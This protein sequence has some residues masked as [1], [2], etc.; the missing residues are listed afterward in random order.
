MPWR[1]FRRANIGPWSVRCC[2][3]RRSHHDAAFD[4]SLRGPLTVEPT[5]WEG[6]TPAGLRQYQLQIADFLVY[7]SFH[8][9]N[10]WYSFEFDDLAIEFRN[11]LPGTVP[12]IQPPTKSKFEKLL[13]ALEKVLPHVKGDLVLSRAALDNWRVSLTVRHA[14][15]LEP[16]WA[17]VLCYD[18]VVHGDVWTA[19]GL[20]FQAGRG[21]RPGEALALAADDLV[22][23]EDN[24]STVGAGL[25]LLGT[26]RRTKSG[27]RQTVQTRDPL[28]IEVMRAVR[29]RLHGSSRIMTYGTLGVYNSHLRVPQERLRMPL[30]GWSAH[31]PRCGFATAAHLRKV[32]VPTIQEVLRHASA[33]TLRIYLDAAA[34]T[35]SQLSVK[36]KPF[37]AHAAF[38]AEHFPTR[39]LHALRYETTR[40][41]LVD[42]KHKTNGNT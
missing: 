11:H 9:C 6:M 22:L 40:R 20:Y 41:T 5:L 23:P 31:S 4:P 39:I 30:T 37:E 10:P 16:R 13:A 19:V 3:P 15:P 32:P 8:D 28:M 29:A 26:R 2:V 12:G 24:P 35:A 38:A 36:L 18:M 25:F 34:V 27:R 17:A 21:L 7:L 1:P 14:P 42:D 33:K